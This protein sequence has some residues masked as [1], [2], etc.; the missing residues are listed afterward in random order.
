MLSTLTWSYQ[1]VSIVQT[2]FEAATHQYLSSTSSPM[3]YNCRFR[4]VEEQGVTV[5]S[6]WCPK[7]L[8]KLHAP[9]FSKWFACLVLLALILT[10]IRPRW[11][12]SSSLPCIASPFDM[13]VFVISR[14][15]CKGSIHDALYYPQARDIPC[16]K[17]GRSFIPSRY[18]D[19]VHSGTTPRNSLD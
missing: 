3:M 17:P 6:S 7:L 14:L 16:T 11:R 1:I 10:W 19:A 8:Y 5:C 12:N 9:F 15:G 18:R 4:S 2:L 13:Q